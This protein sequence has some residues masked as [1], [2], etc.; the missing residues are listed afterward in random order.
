MYL[1]VYKTNR[2][3]TNVFKCAIKWKIC[4]QPTNRVR[5]QMFSPWSPLMSWDRH[6]TDV[7]F[8]KSYFPTWWKLKNFPLCLIWMTEATNNWTERVGEKTGC[9]HQL[10]S[11]I[12]KECSKGDNSNDTHIFYYIKPGLVPGSCNLRLSKKKNL[13]TVF[14]GFDG[15]AHF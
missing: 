14:G 8:H 12:K 4:I 3:G 5:L 7:V 6:Q 9:W 1:W 10:L 11:L 13:Y 15:H 2:T